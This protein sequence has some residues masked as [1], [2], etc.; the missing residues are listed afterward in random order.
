MSLERGGQDSVKDGDLEHNWREVAPQA[1]PLECLG[2][3]A[4][5]LNLLV[6]ILLHFDF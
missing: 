3:T 5:K 1:T 2:Q 6:D 4:A